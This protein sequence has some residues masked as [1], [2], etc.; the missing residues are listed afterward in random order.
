MESMKDYLKPYCLPGVAPSVT[1]MDE[2]P[3]WSAPFGLKLL[4][5]IRMKR[6]IAVLDIGFGFG[7]PLIEI[8][9]R[10]GSDSRIVGI[11]PWE[12]GIIK[13]R[14]KLEVLGLKNVELIQAAAESIPI[15][16]GTFDLVTS[17]N[18]INNVTDIP[19]SF[20][21]C[22]RVAKRGAQFVFT[23][24]TEATMIEFY[25]TLERVLQENRMPASVEAMRKHI[26]EK[27]K[28]AG[29][30]RKWLEH[31]GFRIR[32]VKEDSFVFKYAD[33]TAMLNHCFIRDGFLPSWVKLMPADRL[34]PVFEDVERRLN[35]LAAQH[36]E[37]VLTVPFLTFDCV[38]NG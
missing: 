17:N 21:E 33:G 7:F 11:D 28:P 24:N 20:R 2:T 35:E 25:G 18:G 31:A 38:A 3:L 19:Q 13:A 30:I 16:D 6:G 15:P 29:E 22:R 12:L 1:W 14:E 36:G 23:M 27:R 34:E 8:A 10:L 9:M 5:T 26:Y 32:T 37:L 4:E